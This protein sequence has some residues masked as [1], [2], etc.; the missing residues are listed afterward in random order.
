ML[1]SFSLL[2]SAFGSKG[3][4]VEVKH[5]AFFWPRCSGKGLLNMHF[6]EVHNLQICTCRI[7]KDQWT[8]RWVYSSLEQFSLDIMDQCIPKLQ[9]AV[10]S[11]GSLHQSETE[12][13][14][15]HASI[16]SLPECQTALFFCE[17]LKPLKYI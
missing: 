7:L 11:S 12:M 16:Y 14:F 3:L 15:Y 10:I 6:P 9:S 13:T 8:C 5:F 17:G 2:I 4:E 1:F